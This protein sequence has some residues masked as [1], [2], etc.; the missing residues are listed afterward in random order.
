M[1]RYKVQL[2]PSAYKDLREARSWYRQKNPNLPRQ[3]N[4]HLKSAIEGIN[5]APYANAIR[6]RDVRICNL[7]VFP[8]AIHFCINENINTVLIIAIHHTA[9]NPEIWEKK[10]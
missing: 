10:I 6:Y 8:Y 9:M 5:I 2:L 3:L 4:L 7:K 1:K